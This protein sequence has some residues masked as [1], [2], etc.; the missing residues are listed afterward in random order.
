MLELES[1]RRIYERILEAPGMHLRQLQ[2]D[3]S[4]PL[5]TLEYHLHQMVGAELL[6]TRQEGRLKAFFP[7]GGMDRRDR[8]V[9]YILRQETPRR[10][11][12]EIVNEPGVTFQQLAQRLTISPST[13]SFHLKKFRKEGIMEERRE[14]L[15]K[16]FFCTD[17]ERVRRLIVTYRHTFVD[18][19]VD[20]FADAWLNL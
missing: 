1:R 5:G 16:S 15:H 10:I 19:I 18:D 7:S 20:R 13:L 2:R 4:M 8:D 3:L 12:M 17:P 14:G 6:V 9:L 11:A